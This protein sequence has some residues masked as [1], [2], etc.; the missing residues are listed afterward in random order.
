MSTSA[1]DSSRLKELKPWWSLKSFS[2]GALGVPLAVFFCYVSFLMLMSQISQIHG[3]K[4][5]TAAEEI[6][7]QIGPIVK[8]QCEWAIKFIK[9]N[10]DK[11]EAQAYMAV[12][13]VVR[14]KVEDCLE[15]NG[16]D[17]ITSRLDRPNTIRVDLTD[18][19]K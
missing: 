7:T 19:Y 16:F 10:V 17:V 12:P 1:A 14:D 11:Y 13:L 15:K 2:I 9:G 8:Q 3:T 18:L 6:S 4:A 5:P